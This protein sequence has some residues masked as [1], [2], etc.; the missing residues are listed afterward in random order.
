LDSH[1]LYRG[2]RHTLSIL[3]ITSN[4][5]YGKKTGATPDGRGA[6]EPFAPGANPM[7]GRD[8][9]GTL[10]WL[11]SIS[12]IPYEVCRD[13]ISCTLN[14]VPKSLGNTTEIRQQNLSS[15]IDGY[16]INKGHHLN[17]NMISRETLLDA[18]EHPEKYPQLTIRVSGYAVH[19]N[20]LTLEQKK[21]VISRSFHERM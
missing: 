3:T 4:V 11:N 6:G 18:M 1:P 9:H 16:F 7:P 13:G 20:K 8:K 2:A 12:K 19:F 21:E 17:I 15:L 10:A 5:V 14:M